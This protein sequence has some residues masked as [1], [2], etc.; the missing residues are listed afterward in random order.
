MKQD[1]NSTG[2]WMARERAFRGTALRSRIF[3][4]GAN[5]LRRLGGRVFN[6]D[7]FIHGLLAIAGLTTLGVALFISTRI[8]FDIRW[9]RDK[10]AGRGVMS[11]LIGPLL[12]PFPEHRASHGCGTAPECGQSIEI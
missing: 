6:L 2:I 10:F 5:W 7:I 11:Y 12:G 1:S 9:C 3:R 4:R 8:V